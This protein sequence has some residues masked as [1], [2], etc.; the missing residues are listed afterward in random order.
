[1]PLAAGS[2]GGHV[3][4]ATHE[5]ILGAYTDPR[6]G[7]SLQQAMVTLQDKV[8]RQLGGARVFDKWDSN[9]PDSY[10]TWLRDTGHT[11]F[12][13]VKAQR[14]DGSRIPWSNIA[15]AQPGSAL[16][17]DIVGW[18]DGIK[19]FG[20]PMYF[21][22]NHEP[23]ASGND[24]LG[25]SADF[26]AAWRH[27]V[28]IFRSRGVDNA[29]Y[30]LIMTDYAFVVQDGRN[31][32]NWYPGDGY[33]DAVGADS[34]NW[35][36]CRSS[37]DLPWKSLQEIAEP[38]REFGL[39]HPGKELVLPEFGSVEDPARPNAKANWF[40]G[41]DDLFQQPGWQ[42]FAAVLYFDQQDQSN[43]A[44]KWYVD[45]SSA[46]LTGFKELAADSYF[47]GSVTTAP[48]P[49]PSP[50]STTPTT[51]SNVVTRPAGTMTF[52]DGFESGSLSRWGV[53]S[54]GS[55]STDSP[56]AGNYDAVLGGNYDGRGYL[57]KSLSDP[58]DNRFF[59]ITVRVQRQDSPFVNLLKVYT[60]TGAPLVLV[61]LNQSHALLTRDN[62][63]GTTQ[64]SAKKMSLGTW[65]TVQLHLYIGPDATKMQVSLDGQTVDDLSRT[66]PFGNRDIGQLVVGDNS[67]SDRSFSLTADDVAVGTD[68]LD[69]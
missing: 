11:V 67:G 28:S 37:Q 48:A 44:C 6:S 35:Y 68:N 58:A 55:I 41:V 24:N 4:A 26:I 30:L 34:Y 57:S 62:V 59:R 23:E 13:S 49:A 65:Y 32:S 16:Y 50:T 45:T 17:Q 22:F 1:M 10:T 33:V 38:L 5:V 46:S 8:G 47:G 21:T 36:T 61:G 60:P 51:S 14:R 27:I 39:Q 2:G 9:F 31:V 19:A 18:A 63:D 69:H 40:A 29:K 43:S 42:Q 20:A 15:N 12:L 25:S 52:F 7:D 54:G 64:V 53:V 66:L 56:P 3:S